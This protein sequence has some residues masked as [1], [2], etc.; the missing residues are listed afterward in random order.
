MCSVFFAIAPASPASLPR[1]NPVPGGVAVVHLPIEATVQPTVHF[2]NKSVMV[3]KNRDQWVAVVGLSNEIIPG[4]YLLTL[5]SEDERKTNQLFH[6]DP[7]PASRPQRVMTLPEEMD[8]LEFENSLLTPHLETDFQASQHTDALTPDFELVQIIGRGNYIPYGLILKNNDKTEFIDHPS[9]TYLSDPDTIVFSPDNVIVEQ[10]LD[11]GGGLSV[12]L[13]HGKGLRSILTPLQD[14]IV[15]TGQ[16]LAAG[17]IIGTAGSTRNPAVGR[18][19]WQLI[20]NG[21]PIDPLPFLS[22]P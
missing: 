10:I 12:M 1:H 5:S 8:Y 17:S 21:N 4:I 16:K 14:T 13:N 20:L 19:D 6:V 15:K 3:V 18:V 2:G 7:L 11:T 22:S 9:V